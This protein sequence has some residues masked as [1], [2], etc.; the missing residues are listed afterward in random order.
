[1]VGNF[2]KFGY[3]VD[4][5]NKTAKTIPSPEKSVQLVGASMKLLSKYLEKEILSNNDFYL[6][7]LVTCS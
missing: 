1:M 7:R 4:F 5:K 3:C 6:Y 2:F